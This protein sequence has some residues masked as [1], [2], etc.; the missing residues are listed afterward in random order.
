MNQLVE[1]LSRADGSIPAITSDSALITVL[2][3]MPDATATADLPPRPSICD[4]APATTRRCTSFR[5]G[6]DTSKNRAQRLRR[7]LH[8]LTLLRAF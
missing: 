3:L 6:K 1:R 7:Y 5:C 2:R 8:T 4:A